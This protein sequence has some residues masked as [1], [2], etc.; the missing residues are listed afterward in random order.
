MTKQIEIFPFNESSNKPKCLENSFE[1]E[2][3]Y[4]GENLPPPPDYGYLQEAGQ[5]GKRMSMSSMKPAGGNNWSQ[6]GQ[7]IQMVYDHFYTDNL[8]AANN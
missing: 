2:E 6:E 5:R 4:D 7:E 8:D 1:E 3:E